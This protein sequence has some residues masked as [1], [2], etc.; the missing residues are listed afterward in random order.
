M[1]RNVGFNFHL[2]LDAKCLKVHFVMVA[3]TSAEI[4]AGTFAHSMWQRYRDPPG[5]V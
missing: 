5:I 3:I 1:I 4:I 2:L